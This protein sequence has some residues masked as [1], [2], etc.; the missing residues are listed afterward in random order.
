MGES[1]TGGKVPD[2]LHP[3]SASLLGRVTA[4]SLNAL[5]PETTRSSPGAEQRWV[6]W[7]FPVRLGNAHRVSAKGVGKILRMRP[8]LGDLGMGSGTWSLVLDWTPSGT[9]VYS[10][11]GCLNTSYEE[12]RENEAR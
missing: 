12:G 2:P 8:V 9:G 6:H 3:R 4:G 1:V 10:V 11:P 7:L 5:P